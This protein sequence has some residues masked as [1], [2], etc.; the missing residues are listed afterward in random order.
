M[1]F[2]LLTADAEDVISDHDVG[3]EES[4]VNDAGF[5]GYHPKDRLPTRCTRVLLS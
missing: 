4:I 3:L 2:L 1:L 5:R